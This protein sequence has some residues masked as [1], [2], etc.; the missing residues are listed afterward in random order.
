MIAFFSKFF[1]NNTSKKFEKN[2]TC[3]CVMGPSI[4]VKISSSIYEFD[5]IKFKLETNNFNYFDYLREELI[6]SISYTDEE[7]QFIEIKIDSVK[8]R[9]CDDRYIIINLSNN[10]ITFYIV[11][12]NSDKSEYNVVYSRYLKEVLTDNE[13]K[14]TKLN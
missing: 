14:F 12:I 1:S 11:L 7:K 5:G 4:A 6:E 9:S 2:F 10:E 8:I 3:K 13:I